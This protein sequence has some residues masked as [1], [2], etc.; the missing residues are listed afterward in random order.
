MN[1]ED[2]LDFDPVHSPASVILHFL[3]KQLKQADAKEKRIMHFLFI[4]LFDLSNNVILAGIMIHL[5]SDKVSAH[6]CFRRNKYVSIARSYRIFVFH[7]D[8]YRNVKDRMFV[9]HGNERMNM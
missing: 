9:L 2:K 7:Q 4:S 8:S 6:I 1:G 5:P 3:I